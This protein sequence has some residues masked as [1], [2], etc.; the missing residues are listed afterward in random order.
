MA[1]DENTDIQQASG[2]P[3]NPEPSS[4][5]S[6]SSNLQLNQPRSQESTTRKR[7]RNSDRHR[8]LEPVNEI[9][10]LELEAVSETPQPITRGSSQSR[11]P[12]PKRKR[13]SKM[14]RELQGFNKSPEPD[15][16]SSRSVSAKPQHK[17]KMLREI[18][19]H[20]HSP[21]PDSE[22]DVE[23]LGDWEDMS[24]SRGQR[25]NLA[26]ILKGKN[27][28]PR[29]NLNLKGLMR[30]EL[31]GVNRGS[32]TFSG[33][34]SDIPGR[35]SYQ[36]QTEVRK[37]IEDADEEEEEEEKEDGG[38]D[39]DEDEDEEEEDDDDE[40]DSEEDSEDD[41]DDDSED[42][43]DDDEEGDEED[44]EV[45]DTNEDANE[46]ED[47]D[48]EDDEGDDEDDDEKEEDWPKDIKREGSSHSTPMSVN[49]KMPR[50]VN[51]SVGSSHRS[52]NVLDES[53]WSIW[54]SQK[55]Q[56]ILFSSAKIKIYPFF[57]TTT[58]LP[59]TSYLVPKQRLL[60]P[61]KYTHY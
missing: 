50:Q 38:E 10:E 39:E 46:D 23:I 20:N 9:P 54:D 45:D 6:I 2:L 14:V 51:I 26:E 7:K 53:P 57:V 35:S 31:S 24:L 52:K 56:S 18:E 58:Y 4:H 44:D 11:L 37:E 30:T 19:A 1:P 5:S 41:S 3:R 42:D 47:D 28:T 60:H 15:A 48:K 29:K 59:L 49:R 8:T 13:V 21:E 27:P 16:R 36:R 25:R 61:S 40:D 33:K 22:M 43:S 32:K 34:D 17:S 12:K 55:G